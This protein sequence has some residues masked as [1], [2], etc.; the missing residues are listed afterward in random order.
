LKSFA[1]E[2]SR[3]EELRAF[4]TEQSKVVLK[5]LPGDL[6]EA[7]KGAQ[8]YTEDV[9][10]FR[11]ELVDDGLQRSSPMPRVADIRKLKTELIDIDD[12]IGTPVNRSVVDSLS[13]Y[14]NHRVI[15]VIP[16]S[17]RT[18]TPGAFELPRSTRVTSMSYHRQ[19]PLDR[20]VGKSDLYNIKRK[21]A[22]R[23]VPCSIQALE[24]GLVKPFE[25]QASQLSY[26]PKGPEL[27]ISNP[28]DEISGKKGKKKRK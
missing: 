14:T 22:R 21:L 19:K 10:F 4:K 20:M 6:L 28:F 17:L 15:N 1:K 3:F 25:L 18:A 13:P 24:A 23:N 7:L 9:Y 2:R 11:T 8:S 16:S 26:L 27:L 12:S 5:Q